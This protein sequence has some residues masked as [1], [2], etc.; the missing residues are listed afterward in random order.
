VQ[1]D[2]VGLDG[3]AVVL[4]ARDAHLELARQPVELRVQR[5]PLADDLRV[6]ARIGH[7][8]R[9]GPG[10]VVGGDIANAVA[11]GLDGVHLHLGQLAEDVGDVG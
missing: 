4:G 11:R 9:G 10:E 1:A 2:I 5:R 8:V 3:G 6:G 7:L